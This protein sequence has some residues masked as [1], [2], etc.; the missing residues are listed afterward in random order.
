LIGRTLSHFEIVAKLGEGGMG[1]V[2]R[3]RDQRLD[4]E[5]ALKILPREL[6]TDLQR[7][8]RFEHEAKAVA[9]LNHPHIVTVYSIEESDGRQFIT[10]ELVPGAPLSELIPADGMKLS[11]ALDIATQLTDALA[12]VHARGIT[13]RDLKPA[14]VMVTPAHQVKVLDFGVAK[15]RARDGTDAS[16]THGPTATVAGMIVGTVSYMAPEQIEGRAA[17]RRSDVFSLGIVL[18]LM[19]TGRLPFRGD[20]PPSLMSAILRDDPPPVSRSRPELPRELDRILARCLEK[21]PR[22]RYDSMGELQ[23]DLESLR[24]GGSPPTGVEAVPPVRSRQSGTIAVLP[25]AD[26]SPGGEQEYFCDGMT[27][28]IIN[29][30]VAVPGLK[31]AARTSS[32]GHSKMDQDVRRIGEELGV[33]HVLEGS[34]R[35]AGSRLRV[36]AQLIDVANGYHVWSEKYDRSLEDVFA[37]QD[38]ISAAIVE[39]L[40]MTLGAQSGPDAAARH[41]RNMEAYQLY[42]RGRHCWNRRAKGELPKAI[43]YFRQTI[44]V[45]PTYALAYS[46]LAD[47][48][49]VMG[50]FGY[51]RPEV[52]YSRARAAAERA[53]EISP[54]LA[55]AHCSLGYVHHHFDRDWAATERSYRRAIELKPEYSVA[56]QWFSLPLVILGRSTEAKSSVL[57]ARELDPLSPVIN[58]AVGWVHHFSGEHEKAHR[59]LTTVAMELVPEFAWLRITLGE[60]LMSLGRPQEAKEHFCYAADT[61]NRSIFALGNLGHCLGALGEREEASA[62][63]AELTARKEREYVS[64]FMIAL[65]QAGQGDS[66]AARASLANAVRENAAMASYLGVDPRIRGAGIEIDDLLLDMGL[67][68]REPA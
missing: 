66:A 53:L 27:E 50:F 8:H 10:M 46:G 31:V 62:I 9:A 13:H 20:S 29:A 61:S 60:V 36:T 41:S 56:H 24:A 55:E 39:A 33:A 14:N 16:A 49:N 38:E 15:L 26:M 35:S 5:V 34:V 37:V 23:V 65:V 45:D 57:R 51:D 52:T 1:E 44:D 3:A 43:D 30:L 7:R 54:R 28:E 4:R 17:D 19:L 42:L 59:E 40:Q 18:Y 11:L 22:S 47:C 64:S 25:F 48:Y 63:L 6:A 2:Y 32:F 58:A 68:P 67:Q 21:D 12:A